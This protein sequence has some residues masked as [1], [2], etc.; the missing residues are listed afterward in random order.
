V[1]EK[2]VL[3]AE[4]TNLIGIELLKKDK[5]QFSLIIESMNLDIEIS[6]ILKNLIKN[7]LH[8]NY[9]QICQQISQLADDREKYWSC[10][11]KLEELSKKKY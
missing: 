1:E 5:K 2:E 11:F 6:N 9:E 4:C 3:L 7:G 8:Q 10:L